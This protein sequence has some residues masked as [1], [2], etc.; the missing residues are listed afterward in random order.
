MCTITVIESNYCIYLW[1]VAGEGFL[2]R[3]VSRVEFIPTTA[4]PQPT[5]PPDISRDEF[6]DMNDV[7]TTCMPRSQLGTVISSYEKTIG[8]QKH[9]V[10]SFVD[11]VMHNQNTKFLY[12]AQ[13]HVHVYVQ[14]YFQS[15]LHFFYESTCSPCSHAV[16]QEPE[17][18][19]GSSHA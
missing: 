17:K 4:K 11:E 14:L 13:I 7:L 19:G 5:M 18:S 15:L 10:D 3:Q 9:N 2:S 1:I 8:K 6:Q 12:F 16:G